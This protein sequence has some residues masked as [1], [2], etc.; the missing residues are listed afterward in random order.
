LSPA[1]KFGWSLHWRFAC[2]FCHSCVSLSSAIRLCWTCPSLVALSL[3][4]GFTKSQKFQGWT[5]DENRNWQRMDWSRLMHALCCYK[6]TLLEIVGPT[7]R[8][9][10]SSQCSEDIAR[11]S[12]L[13]V[14]FIHLSWGGKLKIAECQLQEAQIGNARTWMQTKDLCRT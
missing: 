7:S 4:E 12:S 6:Q 10:G 3:V 8:P 2:S 14:R 1:F 5:W 13:S 11:M 9:V